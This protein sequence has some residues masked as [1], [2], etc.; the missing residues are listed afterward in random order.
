MA[1]SFIYKISLRILPRLFSVLSRFWFGSCRVTVSGE[2]YLQEFI[3]RGGGIAAFWHYSIF[4]LF[5]HLRLF[6]AAIMVSASRD[7]EYIARLIKLQGHT[8]VRGSV[9]RRRVSGLKQ[10]LKEIRA[11]KNAG[12]VVDGSQGPPRKVKAGVI[13][14]ASRSGRPILPMVWSSSAKLVFRSWDRTVLP[15]P[16]SRIFFYY[17]KPL[18]VPDNI[19]TDEMEEYRLELEK[20]LN[21]LYDR[22]WEEGTH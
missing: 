9:N 2:E 19:K 16:F 15:L 5:Y 18:F 10:L 17:G 3:S 7:G 21:I 13:L 6:P 20:R 14:L 11:G 4:Y 8:P 12:I 1:D 22:A